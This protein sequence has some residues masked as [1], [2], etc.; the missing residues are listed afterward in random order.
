MSYLAVSQRFTAAEQ[1][2]HL[3]AI[4]PWEDVGDVYRGTSATRSMG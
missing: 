1:S 2:A 4:K 3:A